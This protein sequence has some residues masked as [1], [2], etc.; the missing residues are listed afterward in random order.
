MNGQLVNC[1][2]TANFDQIPESLDCQR[3]DIRAEVFG[4][5][6]NTD[7]VSTNALKDD[8]ISDGLEQAYRSDCLQYRYH[9]IDG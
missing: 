5:A 1:F 8:L 2:F 4:L 9:S 3:N 7:Q 6:D